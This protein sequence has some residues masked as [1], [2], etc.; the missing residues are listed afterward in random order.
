M[1]CSCGQE[2]DFGRSRC[3]HCGQWLLFGIDPRRLAID[4]AVLLALLAALGI[5]FLLDRGSTPTQGKAVAVEKIESLDHGLLS[6]PLQLAVTPPEYDDMGKLLDTLGSGYRYTTITMDDILDAKRLRKY[7]VV[8]L[9]CG[10]VPREWLAELTGRGE[11]DAA[12]MFRPRPEIVTKLRQALR[13]YVRGG[14]T[15]Y[16]SDWQFGVVAT[17]FPEFVDRGKM[18]RGAK[19]T[20]H[21]DVVEPGLQKRL[22][23]KT[24]DLTFE[25]PAW[26]PAA[27]V[28]GKKVTT[29][30]RSS[31]QTA[32]GGEATAALLVQFPFEEGNV[33]F[34]S[35]HNEA[36]NSKTE[37]ELLR[38]LVFTTVNAQLD[39][40]VQRTMVRGGFSPVERNLLSASSKDQSLSESYECKG[41]KSL[42][43]VL[44]FEDRGARLRLTVTSPDGAKTEKEGTST[45]TLDVPQAAA[46]T[47]HYTVTPVEVPYPN[48]PFSLTVGEK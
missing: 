36:Q 31:Y 30:I 20:V 3:P 25:K 39:A 5:V 9:T 37:S 12:G 29:Y 16:A 42:Q 41:S 45:L 46:G 23:G 34:T 6:H 4:A 48:F 18:A 33:I 28:E 32:S 35:F 15:L 8:F 21:A 22:G 44:G 14:G 1:R 17:A 7:D 10:G 2:N 40:G 47:W 13:R 27:F 43:F 24:L 11:R 38:Y 26:Q 19:Q